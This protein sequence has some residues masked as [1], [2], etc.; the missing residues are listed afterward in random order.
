MIG[1]RS[2][3]DPG[4]AWAAPRYGGAVGAVPVACLLA[5]LMLQ[6]STVFAGA[7]ASQPASV[8]T[9]Q[10]SDPPPEVVP[11]QRTW[12]IM[13]TFLQVTVYRS[14]REL[15]QQDLRAVYEQI[16]DI[17]ERMSLYRD[18]SELS[19]LNAR[20]GTGPIAVS[21]KLMEVIATA[22]EFHAVSGG[23]F[24]ITVTPLVDLWGFYD[25]SGSSVPPPEL[26]EQRLV[27]V[28][29]NRVIV[30]A[31]AGTI[32]LPDGVSLDLGGVAKGY[33]VDLAM[34]V[35]EQ[36]GTPAAMVD[37]GGNIA[38]LGEPTDVDGWWIGIR[39]PR[40]EGGLI[41]SVRLESGQAVATSGD[42]ERF[43]ETGGDRYSHIL[44]PRTGMPVRGVLAVT[45]VAARAMV[46]DALSTAAFVLGAESGLELLR[47]YPAVDGVVV[48]P[49]ASYDRAPNSDALNVRT[50]PGLSTRL[51][52]SVR[53][54]DESTRK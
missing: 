7:G 15:A 42:Y 2:S 1:R 30:D 45:V 8:Q 19:L 25:F 12:S 36:R 11:H 13:G 50:T 22:A 24:D 26:L 46:A 21:G 17:D 20:A 4:G 16:V 38:V 49:N 33:A 31:D 34:E 14:D 5:V 44:D 3:T 27:S 43:F 53:V 48:T 32:D 29:M 54:P 18:E 9:D 41:A 28:G 47:D 39:H 6:V 35:L 40:Q 10:A 37:L 23:A 51:N 52:W